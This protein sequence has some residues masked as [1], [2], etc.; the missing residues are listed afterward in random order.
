MPGTP[1]TTPIL[2]LPRYDSNDQATFWTQVNA[3]SDKLD[4]TVPTTTDPRLSDARN[5]LPG[6]VT[7]ASVAPGAAIDESKLSLGSDAA[8]GVP[9]RRSL[10]TGSQQAAA[11]DDPRFSTPAIPAAHGATHADSGPDAVPGL[12][13]IGAVIPYAG[14]SLPTLAGGQ[15]QRWAWADGSLINRDVYATFFSRTGHAY[16]GGQDPLS[17]TPTQGDPTVGPLVRVPDKRGRSSVGAANF[18]PRGA[19]PS[20]PP[21]SNA[22]VQAARGANGGEV[23]HTLVQAELAQHAHG[24]TEPNGG[25]GHAHNI[26]DQGHFHGYNDRNQWEDRDQAGLTQTG[27]TSAAAIRHVHGAQFIATDSRTTGIGIYNGT[28]GISISNAGSNTP[29]NN[30]HPY[31]ADFY[32]VRIA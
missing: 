6:S 11:G 23:Q 28:T 2:G 3:V 24:Y 29:H 17:G 30:L 8:A 21:T 1:P 25:A 10:G 32:I 14:T 13:P 27:A 18:G 26:N 5:P 12:V 15:P 9:S 19:V 31:E 20:T 16:N 7:N 4:T 22:Y